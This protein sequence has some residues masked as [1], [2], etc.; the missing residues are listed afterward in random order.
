LKLELAGAEG[1]IANDG[2]W[3]I[4]VRA[5]TTYTAVFYAKGGEGF[6]GPVTA[7][8]Q[9]DEDEAIVAQ[10]ETKPISSC[11]QKYTLTLKTDGAAPTTAKAKFVLTA[12]GRGSVT[13]SYVSLFPPTYQDAP[14]GLRPD[15]ME[16]LSNL[17]PKFIRLPG[18]NYLEG[19]RFSDRFNWK[20]MIGPPDKRPGHMGCW[21]YR[22]SDGLGL[23]EFMLWCKQLGA[24]PVLGVFAG[25]V[26]NGDHFKAGSPEMAIYTQEALEEIEYFIGSTDTKWGKKRAEDGFSE[27]FPLQ[28]VEIG[29][30]DWFDRSGS[31]DGRFTQMAKAIRERYPQ[32]K[33][34]ASAPV[35]S[36][37]PDLYDDHFY[38]S[39]KQLREMF[40]LYDK[41]TGPPQPL[42]FE[43]GGWNGRFT[44]GT[45]TFVGEW[46]AHEGRL[47]TNLNAALSDA[48]FTMGM[49]RNADVVVMQ[50][51]APLLAN[52]NPEDREK[53]YPRGWQWE[54]NLIGYD[55]L[56]SYGSPSYYAQVML[57]QNRGDVVLTTKLDVAEVEQV[58]EQTPHGR[59]GLGSW[60]TDVEYT[61]L[62]VT[63]PDGK[64]LFAPDLSEQI[65][66]LDS[67]EGEWRVRDNSLRPVRRN[68]STWAFMGDTAWTDY[69]VK[70]RA[71]KR[72]GREG[73]IILWHVTDNNNYQWWNIG[74]WDNTVTRCEAAV[75]GG[76][77]AYGPSADF[78][79]ETNRWYD[80]RLEV[81]GN[82]IRGFVDG[83]LVTDTSYESSQ[84]SAP[85]VYASATYDKATE[86]AFVRVVNAGSA[87]V[88][89]A[90]NVNGAKSVES[91][92]TAIVLQGEPG[93]VNSLDE[94]EKIS[95]KQEAMS[96]ASES[97]RR[98]F[99]AHS[100]TILQLKASP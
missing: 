4:P 90:V 8:L 26:L 45:Q 42:R 67:V 37:K 33:I 99:P 28:Y 48:A 13:F 56:R 32:L 68:S 92:A 91:D 97:F 22:S 83:E 40:S 15:L 89:M 64:E 35:K 76:R 61:D 25:Y 51:Y 93:D 24:E 69:T 58:A 23:P 16:L 20:Q 5:D 14:N 98:R 38:R 55:A 27:P 82:T 49:E 36:F 31:Y 74:G 29:N 73:F 78:T 72:G 100:F 54:Y 18:G 95:P 17:Q 52:V 53:G 65:E 6:A 79:V 3:G 87:P 85:P 47:I 71:R 2:Y 63:T 70:V 84:P 86:T 19:S 11:W 7:T 59:I 30:E 9:T 41:P 77:T 46:A 81:K 88:D 50:C 80:L 10:A 12:E 60:E 96:G 75:D 21:S 57:A 1:G 66:G 44:D 39:P 43:G 62:T 34:I 94:P